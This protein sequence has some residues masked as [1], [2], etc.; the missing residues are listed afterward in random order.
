MIVLLQKYYL[1]YTDDKKRYEREMQAYQQ[2]KQ[3]LM[4]LQ[5]R[6]LSAITAATTSDTA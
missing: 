6:N 5:Q 1:K 2:K 4:E 3:E